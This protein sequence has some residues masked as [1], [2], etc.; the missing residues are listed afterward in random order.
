MRGRAGHTGLGGEPTIREDSKA[1][2]RAWARIPGLWKDLP[3]SKDIWGRTRHTSSGLGVWYDALSPFTVRTQ[4]PE[5]IDNE[6]TRI[7]FYPKRPAKSITVQHP[8]GLRV[9]VNLR[10]RPDN[11]SRYVELSGHSINAF[12]GVGAKDY[13]NA[14]ISGKHPDAAAY[15]LYE[16]SSLFP[17]LH[18]TCS[19]STRDNAR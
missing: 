15:Q 9:A 10:K 14:V 2:E 8:T 16:E 17:A 12:D 3:A 4:D 19:G 11:W 5:P 1:L 13:L 18:E 7:G 6:L